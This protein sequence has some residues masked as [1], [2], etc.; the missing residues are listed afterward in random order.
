AAGALLAAN[1]GCAGVPSPHRRAA[2]DLLDAAVGPQVRAAH[3]GGGQPD[4]GVGG[5][6]DGGGLAVFD[7]DVA[8]RV[9]DCS[10]LEVLLRSSEGGCSGFVLTVRACPGR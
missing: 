2:V 8:G 10:S 6:D 5:L 4:D 3:A 1:P 7:A 9:Q